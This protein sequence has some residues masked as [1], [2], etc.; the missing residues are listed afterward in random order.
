M[1][2]P[3]RVW[4]LA[5]DR[6]GNANQA[7]GVAEAL[8]WPFE[9]RRIRYGP[10][11]ALPNL[12]IGDRLLGLAEVAKRALRPP[13]PDLVL[14]AGRR[15]A[16]VARW[17]RRQ[18]PGV[19]LVQMMWPGSARGLDLVVV[20]EHDGRARAPTVITT[21]GPPH[22]VAPKVL[23]EARAR[24]APA[25][26]HLP[27][28]Y[29]VGRVGGASRH[30]G[31]T[32]EDALALARI[33]A[34][35]AVE[36]GG[37]ILLSTSRRTGTAAE[38]ALEEQ[39]LPAPVWL[40]RFSRGGENPYL[41]LLGHADALVVSADSASM[42][43]EACATGRPVFLA[44]PAGWRDTKLDQLHARLRGLGF[45]CDPAAGWPERAPP[46]LL[47]QEDVARVIRRRMSPRPPKVASPRSTH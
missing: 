46:P 3:P 22:R 25:L 12:L 23:A 30:A 42:V 17:I 34:R 24:L 28:P 33:A 6:P 20:P 2:S 43:T 27:R 45:L 40:H 1:A 16:P 7:L 38:D 39:D 35:L 15:T 41:G 5:D 32:A 14:A 29:V 18:R 21:P 31:F 19:F 37:S 9:I 8:G 47:P 44:H 26:A 11:A 13:W 4:V 36:R 10:L